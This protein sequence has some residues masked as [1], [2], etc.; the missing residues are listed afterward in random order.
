MF[1]KIS[2]ELFSDRVGIPRGFHLAAS[3]L[4]PQPAPHSKA[5]VQKFHIDS[6]GRNPGL[7][8]DE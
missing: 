7:D 1:R 3:S 2:R 8:S 5:A 6:E 4:A